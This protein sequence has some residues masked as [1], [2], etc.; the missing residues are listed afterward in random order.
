MSSDFGFTIV[1][2]L[3]VIAL[4]TAIAGMSIPVYRNLQVQNDLDVVTTTVAQSMRQ[5]QLLSQMGAGDSSWGVRVDADDNNRIVVFKGSSY[6]DRDQ[7]FDETYDLPSSILVS[8]VTEI[9]FT[10][11]R[12]EPN[13]VGV[14]TLT[15]STSETREIFINGKGTIS[16]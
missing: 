13:A 16:Y 3:L 5:A 6:G 14:T 9:V 8:G 11:I 1:E 7:D 4:S 12:G 10:R 2:L 15:S